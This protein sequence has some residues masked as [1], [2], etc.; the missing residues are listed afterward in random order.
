MTA[1]R[2]PM[3]RGS[4]SR[5][6]R[7][8]SAGGSASTRTARPDRAPPVR[9]ERW[10][11]SSPTRPSGAGS[12]RALPSC[13]SAVTTGP[14]FDRDELF[15][16]WRRFFERVSDRCRW[17]SPS[18]TSSGRTPASLE[19]VE[20]L[21]TWTRESPHPDR[22]GGAT[23]DH[24]PAA[25]RG[26]AAG[27]AR[28]RC[29]SN[30]WTTSRC[31]GCSIEPRDGLPPEVT[32][33]VLAHAGGVPLYA[34]EVA[35]ILLARGRDERRALTATDCARHRGSGHA[36]RRHRGA[37]RLAAGRRATAPAVGRGPRAAVPARGT[38]RPSRAERRVGHAATGERSRAARPARPRRGAQLTRPRR[39]RL[40][41]GAR[42]R[43]R[44]S[45][46]WRTTNVGR[47]TSAPRATSSRAGT[48]RPT[49]WRGTSP[50]HTGSPRIH[51]S[52][53]DSRD[54]PWPHS[55]RRRDRRWWCTCP[56]G[57]STS[58]SGRC[59]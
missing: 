7:R 49:C 58:S 4:R 28:P 23:R 44:L 13:S 18:R 36:P 47:C 9:R 8:W 37:H 53:S 17:C 41:A 20:H 48:M 6:W 1:V 15:A 54:G 24:R 22:D 32:R 25:R 39:A 31:I 2:R 29:F 40:R 42:A 14:R 34:V 30:G 26:A 12:S 56:I 35:R 33:Q 5:R 55:G 57:R 16:A 59:G 46:R 10:T 51:G 50:R 43:G 52:G 3:A 38:R 45:A 19:F 27:A 11:S 21:A